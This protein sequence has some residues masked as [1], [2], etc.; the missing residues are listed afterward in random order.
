MIDWLLNEIL[1][2][3]LL[4]LM[5]LLGAVAFIDDEDRAMARAHPCWDQPCNW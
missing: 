2:P 1:L 4:A 3:G 5:V